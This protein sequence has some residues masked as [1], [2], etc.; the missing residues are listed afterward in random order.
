MYDQ[1]KM[2]LCLQPHIVIPEILKYYCTKTFD[3]NNIDSTRCNLQ[4]I[5]VIYW[6]QICIKV[7]LRLCCLCRDYFVSSLE[8]CTYSYVRLPCTLCN[9]K[10][11]N[12]F[13]K[14]KKILFKWYMYYQ[15]LNTWIFFLKSAIFIVNYFVFKQFAL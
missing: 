9:V 11:I 7:D 3:L 1:K 4:N 15:P 6:Q 10:S 13:I 12:T 8:I 14:N 5:S 2:P